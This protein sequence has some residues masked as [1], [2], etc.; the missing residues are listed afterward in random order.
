VHWA[1]LFGLDGGPEY[2]FFSGLFG[3]LVFGGGLAVSAYVTAR[4]HNCHVKG[5]FR[6]GRQQVEGTTFVTCRKHHPEGKP[7]QAGI[8]KT[9]RER[10]HLYLGDKPGHG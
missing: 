7:T 2:N 9:W 1:H 6:V 10:A 8:E 5:C 4:K 3:V